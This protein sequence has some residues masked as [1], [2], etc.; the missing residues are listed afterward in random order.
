VPFINLSDVYSPRDKTTPIGQEL[1][2]STSNPSRSKSKKG[3]KDIRSKYDNSKS[4]TTSLFPEVEDEKNDAAPSSASMGPGAVVIDTHG[5]PE[6]AA[7]STIIA[8]A[9]IKVKEKVALFTKDPSSQG[10]GVS[11]RNIAK[12]ELKIATKR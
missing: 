12:K 10:D 7:A 4:Y 1:I 3:K 8:Q 5:M 9:G 2:F 6:A 11:K